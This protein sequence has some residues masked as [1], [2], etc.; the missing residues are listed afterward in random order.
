MRTVVNSDLFKSRWSCPRCKLNR[1]WRISMVEILERA[2]IELRQ[3]I[4]KLN[5]QCVDCGCV[6]AM[7]LSHFTSG[8]YQQGKDAEESW[9][10]A[11]HV[12]LLEARC[13][14]PG[15]ET[16]IRVLAPCGLH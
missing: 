9:Q 14:N 12:V 5:F 15:C 7:D 4:K 1:Y 3:E 8:A 2:Q 13:T 6:S 10:H 11:T 16:R